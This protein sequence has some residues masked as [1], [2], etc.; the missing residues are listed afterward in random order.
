MRLTKAKKIAI[1]GIV[2]MV[3]GGI[4]VLADTLYDNDVVGMIALFALVI[5]LFIAIS[6]DFYRIRKIE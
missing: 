4:L 5:G 3:A 1:I 6:A 2:M